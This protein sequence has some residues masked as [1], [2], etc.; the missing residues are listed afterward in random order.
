MKIEFKFSIFEGK[1][2]PYFDRD[3]SKDDAMNYAIK[4]YENIDKSGIQLTPT[5]IINK[6]NEFLKFLKD[7]NN[8]S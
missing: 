2:K 5:D 6:A 8:A 3:Y 7:D 4:Y 1:E